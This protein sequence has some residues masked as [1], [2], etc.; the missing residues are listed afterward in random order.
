MINF[1]IHIALFML[2]SF[3]AFGQEDQTA[4]L[5]WPSPPEQERIRYLSSISSAEDVESE[6]GWLGKIWDLIV[7][8]ET[9]YRG[10]VQPVGVAVDE[11]G[12]VF[13]ADPGARC[14][15]MF[16]RDEEEYMSITETSTDFLRS[17]VCIV[18]AEN[19]TM[20]VSDA[21][22]KAVFVYDEGGDPE[23]TITGG[24]ERPTGLCIREDTLYVIDTG[25][26][27][28]HLLNLDGS[29]IRR[30]G[31]RG[32]AAGQF[33]FPVFCTARENLYVVD[34][35]NFRV[36][37]IDATDRTVS[38]FGH[39]GTKIGDFASPK[40]IALDSDGHIYVADAMFDAVQIFDQG[41]NLLLVFGNSGSSHG[42]FLNP[43]GLAI[44]DEDR[45][46][47]VDALNK[48]VEV[49]QYVKGE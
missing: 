32:T 36:Q 25:A 19:G 3:S 6:P 31:T 34:A 7:G 16:D 1:V 42:Q 11:D 45:I 9:E 46:Y 23:S 47:V 8:A 18:F 12:R 30:F 28:V 41:A 13:V 24:F 38:M 5:V 10:L 43:T 27:V 48:R 21:E 14:V 37:E 2:F 17:P 26:N 22:Q 44:D 20:Y 39:Q 40:G 49:Y 33:N 35:M 4:D 29:Y 15:H